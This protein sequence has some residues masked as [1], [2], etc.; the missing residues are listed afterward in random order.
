VVGTKDED[1]DKDG[2]KEK[3]STADTGKIVNLMASKSNPPS[4]RENRC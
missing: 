3:K 2:K 4:L 1:K